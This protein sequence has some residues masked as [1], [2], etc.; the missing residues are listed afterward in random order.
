MHHS[1]RTYRYRLIHQ[2]RTETA[3]ALRFDQGARCCDTIGGERLVDPAGLPEGDRP[4][5]GATFVYVTYLDHGTAYLLGGFPYMYFEHADV[6]RDWGS[7][8][9]FS[10][11]EDASIIH[12]RRP[13]PLH[14]LQQLTVARG[15][16]DRFRTDGLAFRANRDGAVS[17]DP[18]TLRHP[19]VLVGGWHGLDALLDWGE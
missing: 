5:P 18:Q 16:G 11:P 9:L 6:D 4:M 14:V 15:R 12:L 19:T 1:D 17:L 10:D 7:A 13:I 3:L 2:W 8:R